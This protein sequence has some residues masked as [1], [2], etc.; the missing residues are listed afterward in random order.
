MSARR[1]SRAAGLWLPVLLWC[2]F[3]Y[4]LS[5]IPNL[6]TQWGLWDLIFRKCAHFLEYAILGCLIYRALRGSCEWSRQRAFWIALGLTVLYAVSDELHQTRV[7]GRV[8][9]PRDVL[10]DSVGA[11]AGLRVAL[12]RI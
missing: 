6:K 9:S 2:S 5:G 12:Q 7:R 3:I 8:G 11:W 1:F 10:I 4:Y